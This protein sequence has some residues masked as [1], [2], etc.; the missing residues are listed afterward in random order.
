[1]AFTE[2]IKM[3]LGDVNVDGIKMASWAAPSI[4]ERY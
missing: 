3:R 4:N 2:T 1:M